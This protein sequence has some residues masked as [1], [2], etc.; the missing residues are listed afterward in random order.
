MT[1]ASPASALRPHPPLPDLCFDLASVA[2]LRAGGP[3][4]AQLQDASV[5][6]H[7][8]GTRLRVPPSQSRRLGE[9]PCGRGGAAAGAGFRGGLALWGGQR[10]GAWTATT[11]LALTRPAVRRAPAAARP[12]RFCLPDE[13]T[14]P[15]LEVAASTAPLPRGRDMRTAIM[16]DRVSTCPSHG[17]G[18][19]TASALLGIG[20][21]LCLQ[22][23]E[24][25]NALG[26]R[27]K[28]PAVKGGE[29]FQD[30]PCVLL[31]WCYRPEKRMSE[32]EDRGS[33]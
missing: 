30:S 31:K 4:G 9:S 25:R 21:A 19:S 23:T 2:R 1:P 32:D 5:S 16:G 11:G 28:S 8:T 7:F 12:G 14:A 20:A 33:C 18:L 24:M 27:L 17:R 22:R 15:T 3:L 6:C 26:P 13:D 10:K 29:C